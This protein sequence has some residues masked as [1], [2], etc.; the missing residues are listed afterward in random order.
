MGLRVHNVTDQL[1]DILDN[2][3]VSLLLPPHQPEPNINIS[4]TILCPKWSS[5]PMGRHNIIYANVI[6]PY[7]C[8]FNGDIY[9]L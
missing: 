7:A 8:F 9:V 5:T 2:L 1:T 4:E 6:Q 3:Q